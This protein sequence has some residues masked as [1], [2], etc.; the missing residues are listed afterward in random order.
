MVKSAKFQMTIHI[1]NDREEN[2][3]ELILYSQ[4]NVISTLIRKV[5]RMNLSTCYHNYKIAHV[6]TVSLPEY[7]CETQI[8]LYGLQQNTF[9]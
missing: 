2:K 7:F 3:I 9:S 1:D 4:G 5:C 8:Y 6:C